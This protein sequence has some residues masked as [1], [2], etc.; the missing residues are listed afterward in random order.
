M[1]KLFKCS[2]LLFSMLALSSCA[3]PFQSSKY[4]AW[5][6]R[7]LLESYPLVDGRIV[8]GWMGANIGD[9]VSAK[10]Y[11]FTVDK[12]EFLNEY[13]GYKVSDDSKVLVHATITIT[14]T[15]N[16]DVFLFEDDFALVWDLDK[17]DRS[18]VSS[19]KAYTD[20]MLVNEMVVGVGETKTIDTVYEI[21][22]KTEKPM[23]L[24]YYEQYLEDS[25]KG[26]KYYVYIK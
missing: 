14:N 2:V 9:K 3:L 16:K 18:Y 22:K 24:F 8:G 19:M 5:A 11:D 25:Q 4:P 15:T 20:T 13:E 26:N 6:T 12:V 10:W 23:A 7:K 17:E 1:K 21:D